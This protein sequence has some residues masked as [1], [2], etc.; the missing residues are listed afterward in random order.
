[1]KNKKRILLIIL[2][3]LGISSLFATSVVSQKIYIK[4]KLGKTLLIECELKNA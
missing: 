2:F 1:M 3:L 4:N